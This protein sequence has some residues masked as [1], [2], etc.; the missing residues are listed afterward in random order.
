[1][2]DS[3]LKIVENCFKE[4]KEKVNILSNLN[5]IERNI[6]RLFDLN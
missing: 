5:I 3:I 1:M 2:S 6:N 4:I